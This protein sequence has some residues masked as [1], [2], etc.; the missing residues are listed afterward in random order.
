MPVLIEF[1]ARQSGELLTMMPLYEFLR[2]LHDYSAGG[3]VPFEDLSI[4]V[5][6][7][8]LTPSECAHA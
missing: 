6:G 4:I 5:D 7:K 1:R 3:I 8:E 2:E